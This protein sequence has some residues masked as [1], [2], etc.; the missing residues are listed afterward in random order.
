MKTLLISSLKSRPLAVLL[1]L[2]LG[3]AANA[4]AWSASG[5]VK[6]ASGSLLSGVAVTVKDSSRYVTTSDASGAF[7]FRESS[8]GIS[9]FG[10]AN[11]FM[12]RVAG[13]D[14]VVQCPVD[15]PL[16]L[17]LV[18]VSGRSLWDAHLVAS[19]GVARTSLP[20]GLGHGAVFLRIRHAAGA[21]YQ[22]VVASAAGL[23][24]AA[25]RAAGIISSYPVLVFKKAGYRDTTY[26]MTSTAQM[27]IAVTMAESSSTV[28]QLPTTLKWQS[29]GILVSPKP[30]AKHSNVYSVKDPT[31][32][33]YNG[34][35]LVYATV[36]IGSWSFEFLKFSDFSKAASATPTYMDQIT[37][38]SGY[39]CAPELFYFEPQ[40]KWYILSQG[41]PWYSTTTTPDVPTSW[42]APKTLF[43]MPTG[44]A[45]IDF[46]PIC[47][48]K[49]CF[50]FFTGDDGKLYHTSTTV[51][52]FPNGWSNTVVTDLTYKT[53]VLFEG[54]SHYKLKGLNK[55]LT[56]IEGMG[57]R[58]RTYSAWLADTLAGPWKEWKV[59]D[60]NPFASALNVTYASG[61]TD[62]TNDVSHGE[63]LRD[64][65]D[66]TQTV[67]PCNF[68]LFYQGQDPKSGVSDY[69]Q[70]PYRLGL[71]TAQ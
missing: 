36:Y 62:W 14:L 50:L 8:T 28:C 1:A 54:S 19:Q 4:V 61:V 32:Q 65:P 34:E 56:L 37:G 53:N 69:G 63:L 57:S 18:D 35:W 48:S 44:Q 27:G 71:L 70:L 46:F 40:K 12:A 39:K 55:Y 17:S 26:A 31:I 10:A 25:P 11:S 22:A 21:E 43:N 3:A 67:D 66:Q 9:K 13:N 38:F 45:N 68:Q 52:N 16:D 6:S 7:A 20:S 64:N 2:S 41:G 30:D 47:D 60:S 33:R 15:G 59:G 23:Q 51:A 58:G 42:S 49:N 24:V 5:T 29:S